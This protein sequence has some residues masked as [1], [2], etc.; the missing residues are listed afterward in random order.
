MSCRLRSSKTG[1]DGNPAP[2]SHDRAATHDYATT[3]RGCM[4]V[5][6]SRD[7]PPSLSHAASDAL[8]NAERREGKDLGWKRSFRA[9]PNATTHEFLIGF[10]A[11]IRR[12]PTRVRG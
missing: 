11:V 10:F 6:K 2:T 7:F 1:S 12:S 5:D 4:H 3:R 9:L 8:M